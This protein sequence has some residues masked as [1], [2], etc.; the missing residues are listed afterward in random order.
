[1]TG[2]Y[3]ISQ[4]YQNITSPLISILI[5]SADKNSKNLSLSTSNLVKIGADMTDPAQFSHVMLQSLLSA[6]VS[7]ESQ[8][9]FKLK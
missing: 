2:M 5:L 8:I 1:M 7:K 3:N 4:N 6:M 9:N